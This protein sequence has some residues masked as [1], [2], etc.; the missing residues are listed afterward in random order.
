MAIPF[1]IVN[2]SQ[3]RLDALE[4]RWRSPLTQAQLANPW[5]QVKLDDTALPGLWTFE[6]VE[7]K[8]KAQVNKAAGKDGGSGTIRGL[9]NPEFKLTGELYIPS[10]FE[11][12]IKIAQDLDVVG[13]PSAREQHTVEHPL[14]SLTGVRNV[15]V[16]SFRYRAPRGGGPLVVQLGC[17]GVSTRDG[18]SKTPP[19]PPP[20]PPP[21]VKIPSSGTARPISPYMIKPP[22]AA[23]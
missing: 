11:A 7:R 6:E 14:A 3:A 21:T 19:P 15:L 23:R 5:Q 20:V 13:K 16:L 18:A 17:M 22:G 2:L 12:W 4:A 8:L 10:H 9:L 1:W